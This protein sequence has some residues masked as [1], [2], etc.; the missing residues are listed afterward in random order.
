MDYYRPVKAEVGNIAFLMLFFVLAAAIGAQVVVSLKTA[1]LVGLGV[2]VF[3]AMVA[4]ATS[5]LILERMRWP[6]DLRWRRSR[7]DYSPPPDSRPCDQL[8]EAL[9]WL[10]DM[11]SEKQIQYV[12]KL[13]AE[14]EAVCPGD[15]II[16][17]ARTVLSTYEP[18]GGKK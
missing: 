18:I 4:I 3:V 7:P 9:I 2:A 1:S 6:S 8:M 14:C 15:S 10:V 12:E 13:M 17:T 5:L 11:P 16:E